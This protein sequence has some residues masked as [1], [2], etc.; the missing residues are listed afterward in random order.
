MKY[1]KNGFYSHPI[2]GAKE[3]SD[4]TCKSLLKAQS[5][6]SQI[7][8]NSEGIPEAIRV[9]P[10]KNILKISDLKMYLCHTDWMVIK[11]SELGVS[12]EIL[13]PEIAKKRAKAREEINNLE[14]LLNQ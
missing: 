12:L 10:D 14:T 8:E 6:G 5:K 7:V 4:E 11:S 9:K 1:W 2:E 13:Y 3:I